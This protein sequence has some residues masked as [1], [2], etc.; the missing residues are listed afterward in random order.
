MKRRPNRLGAV[1]AKDIEPV[2][3]RLYAG[4]DIG[5]IAVAVVAPAVPKIRRTRRVPDRRE[6]R[7][8]A[9]RV[10]ILKTGMSFRDPV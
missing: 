8:H 4:R 5:Q 10:G 2:L 3:E 7:I 6:R 9:K 1:I